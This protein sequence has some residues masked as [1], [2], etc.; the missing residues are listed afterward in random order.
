MLVFAAWIEGGVGGETTMR[1]VDDIATAAAAAAA[2]AFCVRAGMRYQGQLRLSWWLFAAACGAWALGELIWALYDLVL[3]TSVPVPSWADAAYLAAIPPTAAALLVHPAIRGRAI[4][5]MRSLLDGLV[6]AAALLFIGWTLLLEPLWHTSDLS[7]LGG[8]VT[9][10]YPLGD[11]VILLLITLVIRGTTGGD[12]LGLWC[13]LV[14]LLAITLS[15]SMYGYLT[16]VK[17]YATGDV[18]DTGW[19]AGYLGIAL[20]AYFARSEAGSRRRVPASPSLT[21]AAVVTPFLPLFGALSLVAIR[22]E[23]GASPRPRRPVHGV[24]ARGPR[25]APPGA[26]PRRPHRARPRARSAPRRPARRGRGGS[27]RPPGPRVLAAPASEDL[28]STY[29]SARA[30]PRRAAPRRTTR[31]G[32]ARVAARRDSDA[33]VLAILT[34]TATLITFYDL[35]ILAINAR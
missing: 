9:L 2:T 20:A 24:R 1:Y 23:L 22:T 31:P 26:T 3:G 29:R 10:A 30:A 4:G 25:L 18:I 32:R 12:R 28:V 17:N 13:L 16:E 19:F 11:I 5:K 6:I 15:D 14:G 33:L 34:I 27:K 8:A 21:S 7:T 35:F